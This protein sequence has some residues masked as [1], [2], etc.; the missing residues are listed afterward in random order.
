VNNTKQKIIKK[1]QLDDLPG[2][3]A[4]WAILIGIDK[5]E[6]WI[7]DLLYLKNVINVN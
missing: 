7:Y 6:C 4:I 5:A 3:H 1:R 2:N